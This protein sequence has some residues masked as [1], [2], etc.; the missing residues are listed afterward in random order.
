MPCP[1]RRRH[2]KADTVIGHKMFREVAIGR[3]DRGDLSQTRFR[4]RTHLELAK[5]S[6]NAAARLGRVRR[7]VG[8]AELLKDAA[9][10]GQSALI[11]RAPGLVV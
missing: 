4:G 11:D 9:Y 5:D 7:N 10:L 6:L 8:D 2:R 1:P 3:R